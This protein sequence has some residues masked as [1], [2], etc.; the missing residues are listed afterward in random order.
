MRYIFLTAFATALMP[1]A[2][3]A[4][5][6]WHE[7]MSWRWMGPWMGPWMWIF[8]IAVIAFIVFFLARRAETPEAG[9]E[10]P[11]E[12][13][14]RRLAKGEIT[15]EEFERLKKKIET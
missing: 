7:M 10:K 5:E 3:A 8:W 12:I 2:P 6:G 15:E 13:L 11:V 1:A 4:A 9:L 14:R